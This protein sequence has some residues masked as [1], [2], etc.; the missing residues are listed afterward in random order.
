MERKARREEQFGWASADASLIR[1][2]DGHELILQETGHFEREAAGLAGRERF[3][4]R[5]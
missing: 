2:P 3:S 5:R 1:A 4:D